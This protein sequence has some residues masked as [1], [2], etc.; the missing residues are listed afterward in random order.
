MRLRVA[1]V[2]LRINALKPANELHIAT[3]SI[4]F[5]AGFK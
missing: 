1:C 4:L 3:S 5:S 2:T